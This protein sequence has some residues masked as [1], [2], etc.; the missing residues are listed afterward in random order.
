MWWNCRQ[1][2][3]VLA[4]DRFVYILSRSDDLLQHLTQGVNIIVHL[5]FLHKHNLK[6][7]SFS[8]FC[9][10]Y[11]IRNRTTKMQCSTMLRYA[12][13]MRRHSGQILY[14]WPFLI[15]LECHVSK[16]IAMELVN[17]QWFWWGATNVSDF[18]FWPNSEC[19]YKKWLRK[20]SLQWKCKIISNT[21]CLR[22]RKCKGNLIWKV[23]SNKNLLYIMKLKMQKT[24][25]LWN[26]KQG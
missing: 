8:Q 2:Q 19:L 17:F 18:P 12:V 16:T 9:L 4:P 11:I 13:Y 21:L 3:T 24:L 15:F 22:L 10:L 23:S 1:L 25:K 7:S 5:R 20:Y 6:Y 26:R 14:Y